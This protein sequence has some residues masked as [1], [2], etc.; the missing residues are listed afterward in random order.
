MKKILLVCLIVGLTGCASLTAF[1]TPNFKLEPTS[2]FYVVHFPPD[3]RHLERIIADEITLRGYR[4]TYG[5]E[6]DVYH[7]ADIIVTYVDHW[8]WDIT[9]YMIDIE[10]QFRRA[11]DKNLIARG[12]SY[13]PSLV[14]AS[15][16]K[17]IRETLTKIFNY[18][19]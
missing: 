16:K 11:E 18:N 13:H 17:M 8:M 10:I 5:E 6:K 14:R 2:S 4:V 15:P 9:N 12:K 1:H 7:D 3:K 19:E